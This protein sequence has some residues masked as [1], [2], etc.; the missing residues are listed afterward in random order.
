MRVSEEERSVR[1]EGEA[2]SD[3]AHVSPCLLSVQT[4]R[5]MSIHAA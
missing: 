3:F 1:D 2:G 5:G 4:R